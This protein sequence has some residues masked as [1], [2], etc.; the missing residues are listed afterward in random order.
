MFQDI[1]FALFPSC[2]INCGVIK[3]LA[4][5]FY[6]RCKIQRYQHPQFSVRGS[7]RC[8]QKK[9][10]QNRRQ[11]RSHL[12]RRQVRRACGGGKIGQISSF[13]RRTGNF[14]EPLG[15]AKFRPE[16]A[17]RLAWNGQVVTHRLPP[18]CD[19][20]A[21]SDRTAQERPTRNITCLI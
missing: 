20:I 13:L 2:R 11:E 15:R 12:P 10:K 1:L 9:K 5:P 16:L 4:V 19:C 8:P 7:I 21:S 14:S 18:P 6:S 3:N 17:T